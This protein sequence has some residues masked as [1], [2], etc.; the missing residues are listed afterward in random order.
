MDKIIGVGSIAANRVIVYSSIF[1]KWVGLQK[2]QY[3]LYFKDSD[4]IPFGR[5]P[6]LNLN[7]E[8][9]YKFYVGENCSTHGSLL[10]Q[11]NEDNMKKLGSNWL[12]NPNFAEFAKQFKIQSAGRLWTCRKLL[13]M[14]DPLPSHEIVSYATSMLITHGVDLTNYNLLYSDNDANIHKCTLEDYIN[15]CAEPF[16]YKTTEIIPTSN[17]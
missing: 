13:V 1:T 5:F 14:R 16:G 12:H 9:S 6:L 10:Q 15:G 4:A 17:T 3:T 2:R 7:G 11:A 8:M